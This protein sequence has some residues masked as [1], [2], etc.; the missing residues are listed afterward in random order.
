MSC[1][2]T[3]IFKLDKNDKR[4]GLFL[5]YPYKIISISKGLKKVQTVKETCTFEL[6]PFV[7][8]CVL[9]YKR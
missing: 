1:I 6:I 7:T 5:F 4:K 2:H 8:C 3:L 9:V